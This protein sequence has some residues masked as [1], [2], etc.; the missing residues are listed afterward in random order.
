MIEYR[1]HYRCLVY[2]C[3]ERGAGE[4]AGPYWGA[5]NYV[6]QRLSLVLY[7]V[8][9]RILKDSEGKVECIPIIE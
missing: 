8:S 5:I 7:I 4:T 9:G 1:P 2:R 3:Y 6:K